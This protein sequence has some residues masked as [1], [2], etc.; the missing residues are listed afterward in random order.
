M[1]F[2][3]FSKNLKIRP[4]QFEKG[5]IISYRTSMKGTLGKKAALKE[6]TAIGSAPNL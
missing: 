2:N 4:S 5:L 6:D 3:T 1:G